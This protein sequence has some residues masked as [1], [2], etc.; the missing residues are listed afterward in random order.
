MSFSIGYL[1]A[2]LLLGM[3]G[4]FDYLPEFDELVLGNL[5][6]MVEVDSIE[7]LV[8]RD[9]PESDLSPVLLCLA[10][11]YRLVSVLVEYL[12][13]VLNQLSKVVG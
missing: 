2:D 3:S 9:L 6:I 8:R 7:E 5:T 13:N 11:V 12:K 10:P 4:A 1:F